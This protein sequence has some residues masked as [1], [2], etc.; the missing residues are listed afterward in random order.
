M[1]LNFAALRAAGLIL[2]GHVLIV[3]L[4]IRLG[5]HDN[6]YGVLPLV[7]LLPLATALTAAVARRV[8]PI[9]WGEL[10]V[11]VLMATLPLSLFNPVLLVVT[12][13]S[14][15]GA[16]LLPLLDSD[17]RSEGSGELA[18][19]RAACCFTAVLP[20][21]LLAGWTAF[22]AYPS[23]ERWRIM[24][25]TALVIGMG[26][27][28]V[29]VALALFITAAGRWR[30]GAHVGVVAALLLPLGIGIWWATGGYWF[31]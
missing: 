6:L 4:A 11:G 1:K 26:S 17:L 25:A 22:A 14:A 16:F 21:A 27:T 8:W 24:G 3:M 2:V 10:V 28:S 12:G 7:P 9:E 23:S 30:V 29:L 31:P 15:V 18:V 13:V 20:Y 19:D 5:Y